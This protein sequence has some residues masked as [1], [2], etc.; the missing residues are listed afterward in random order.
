ML[1]QG[2]LGNLAAILLKMNAPDVAS[3]GCLRLEPP[4]NRAIDPLERDGARLPG[5]REHGACSSAADTAKTA[6]NAFGAAV[7]SA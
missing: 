2:N 5:L 6:E 4:G 1:A 7:V 3:H